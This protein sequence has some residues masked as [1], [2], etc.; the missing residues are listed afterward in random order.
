MV[1]LLPLRH[2][3]N[4][5]KVLRP[6]SVHSTYIVQNIFHRF[7][8][9]SSAHKHAKGVEWLM[10]QSS[11]A[12]TQIDVKEHRNIMRCKTHNATVFV[13]RCKRWRR[14]EINVKHRSYENIF[15]RK[16]LGCAAY[17]VKY[18]LIY[19]NV[20]SPILRSEKL[21]SSCTSS[22]STRLKF[23]AMNESGP[24]YALLNSMFASKLRSP[25]PWP[26]ALRYFAVGERDGLFLFPSSHCE[27]FFLLLMWS[28]VPAQSFWKTLSML[29]W[30][31]H[32]KTCFTLK[33]FA[34]AGEVVH[35]SI[36]SLRFIRWYAANF[37]CLVCSDFC[38][39]MIALM[40]SSDNASRV[41]FRVRKLVSSL[42]D[43]RYST[44]DST[45][46]H[47]NCNH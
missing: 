28:S 21:S 35:P 38:R 24:N 25:R 16:M 32:L 20:D 45:S 27:W 12:N 42:W 44:S 31:L 18:T 1:Y 47:W 5:D 3:I 39:A 29:K 11:G 17:Q 37:V 15:R 43:R 4:R 36:L 34:S 23:H 19:N 41:S 10:T 14:W 22:M 2:E 7:R 8:C 13:I 6:L 26:Q 30:G 46:V 40:Q 33:L 9:W